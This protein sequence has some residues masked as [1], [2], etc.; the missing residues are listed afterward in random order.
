MRD[1]PL[2]ARQFRFWLWYLST[3][4][5]E[6]WFMHLVEFIDVPDDATEQAVVAATSQV[7][8]RHEALRTRFDVA[9]SGA[10]VRLV[11][12][13]CTPEVHLVDS[14]HP[15]EDQNDL[16]DVAAALVRRPIELCR[17]WP[18]RF[19]LIGVEGRVR[20][21]CL[22]VHHVAVDREAL[23]ILRDELAEALEGHAAVRAERAGDPYE[24]ESG[25]RARRRSDAAAAH[26]RTAL[27]ELPAV[28][29]PYHRDSARPVQRLAWIDSPSLGHALPMIAGR[30]RMSAPSIVL[31][32]FDIALAA[33]T[34]LRR[35]RWETIVDNRPPGL[36]EGTIGC[37]I[38]PTLVSSDVDAGGTFADHVRHV[39]N[40]MLLGVR[41]SVCDY[42]E[43]YELEVL[44]ALR[45][46]SNLDTPL[47]YNFKGA[48][49]SILESGDGSDPGTP[50]EFVPSEVRWA[51]RHDPSLMFVRVH[52]LGTLPTLSL[53]ARD[54]LIG[55]EDHR[56]LLLAVERILWSASEN[57]DIVVGELLTAVS[58][59]SWPRP[60][61]WTELSDS[62]WV[63]LAAT[64]AFLRTLDA[65]DD[66][67]CTTHTNQRGHVLH[68]HID[69]ADIDRALQAL[70]IGCRQMLYEAGAMIPDRVIL[71]GPAETTVQWS[72]D[73]PP[74]ASVPSSDSEQALIDNVASLLGRYPASLDLS[75][76]EQGGRAADL[77]RLH[78]ALAESGWDGVAPK[79]L[80]GPA[81][82]RGVAAQLSRITDSLSE[83]G[84]NA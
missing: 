38:D 27:P 37:F 47:M 50:K 22:V 54:S 8:S 75:L 74:P 59:P 77:I 68:A 6:R 67:R 13:A 72:P 63:D 25:S 28:V 3:P 19:L 71:H 56:A 15:A 23:A 1:A 81:T 26:W 80:L 76:L 32:A 57:P 84:E 40:A 36:D 79:D 11:D 20:Q 53:A 82:L 9:E 45:R 24:L 83:A 51:Q 66:V 43:L 16:N 48:A 29:L 78:R 33:W 52:R 4:L 62:R 14:D 30:L 35:W 64:E 65:V 69:V 7:V 61:D 73:D 18:I 70:R 41:H 17:Q 34:G 49:S 2:T 60:P 55:T 39:S 5:D 42:T 44:G 12:P 58:A 31:A 10:M 21:V 46:G